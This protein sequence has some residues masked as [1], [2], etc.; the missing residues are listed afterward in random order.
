M[1]SST[2]T[3]SIILGAMVLD[4]VW[5]ALFRTTRK[6]KFK[7]TRTDA[8][9]FTFVTDPGTFSIDRNKRTLT[10]S[11]SKEDGILSF[12]EIA[13]IKY[14]A[15]VRYAGL[16]EVYLGFDLT[17]SMPRHADTLYWYSISLQTADGREIPLFIIGQYEPRE[18]MLSWYIELQ[19]GVLERL[20][21]F[22]DAHGYSLSVLESIQ[23]QF[24]KSA[25]DVPL[26]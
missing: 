4:W 18:F 6:G 19:G 5:A 26:K 3:L 15:E 23:D 21:L 10:Y 17:D 11:V 25:A 14:R 12:E 2:L 1:D 22:K 13:G 20:G 16:E 24:D 8:A 9:H 7:I